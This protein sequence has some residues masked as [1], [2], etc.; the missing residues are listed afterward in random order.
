MDD[1]AVRAAV[2]DLRIRDVATRV[3]LP[4]THWLGR[5]L[6]V[7]AIVFCFVIIVATSAI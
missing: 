5:V 7:T 2:R 1:T 3:R 4:E 6:V